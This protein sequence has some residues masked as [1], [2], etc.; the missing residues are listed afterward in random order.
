MADRSRKGGITGNVSLA[1]LSHLAWDTRSP[2][3]DCERNAPHARRLRR[4][5]AGIST[6]NSLDKCR[7]LPE[8]ADGKLMR[9]LHSVQMLLRDSGSSS[10]TS[11]ARWTRALAESPQRLG[12][13]RRE[14]RFETPES[15]P[16]Q[17]QAGP[18]RATLIRRM[19]GASPCV[20]ALRRRR[21]PRPAPVIMVARWSGVSA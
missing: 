16:R 15:A 19:R 12:A 14:C 2:C 13:F 7:I 8:L 4:P 1:W 20:G 3:S 9:L 6:P 17:C 10:R 18:P 5:F 11:G 21:S